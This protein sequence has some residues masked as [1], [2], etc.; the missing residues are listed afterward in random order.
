MEIESLTVLRA[1][2]Q[3]EMETQKELVS[4]GFPQDFPSYRYHIGVIQGLGLALERLS[5]SITEDLR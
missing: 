2:L 3:K 1:K 5:D 4:N